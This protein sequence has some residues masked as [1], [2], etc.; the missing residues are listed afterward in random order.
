M[1]FRWLAALFCLTDLA[2]SMAGVA[3]GLVVEANPVYYWFG[4]GGV[5]VFKAADLA[6]GCWL[7]PR[8]YPETKEWVPVVVAGLWLGVVGHTIRLLILAG[9]IS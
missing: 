3:L 9:G 5:A 6:I 8:A 2:L 1:V 4:W 7:I